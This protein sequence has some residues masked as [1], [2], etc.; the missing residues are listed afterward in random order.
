[1][2]RGAGRGPVA[3][4][5]GHV[6]GSGNGGGRRRW[7]GGFCNPE[8]SGGGVSRVALLV[9]DG[10]LEVFTLGGR[11]TAPQTFRGAL[12]ARHWAS[13][14]TH[15]HKALARGRLRPRPERSNPGRARE[16]DRVV[17]AGRAAARFPR[18]PRLLS[19]LARR[20]EKDG[21]PEADFFFFF[22]K[23]TFS[24]VQRTVLK[25]EQ[26]TIG[27][28]REAAS[29]H[30]FASWPEKGHQLATRRNGIRGRKRTL[31]TP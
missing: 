13:Q 17:R 29:V 14:P 30:A 31:K 5:G 8:G 7:W 4:Q 12:R 15:V 2:G 24:G 1:M 27:F 18:Q 3:G 16:S 20:Q 6:S 23:L 10:D 22:F 9:W 11:G 28:S 26:P 19:H 21:V 25:D